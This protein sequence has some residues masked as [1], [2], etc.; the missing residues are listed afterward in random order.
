MRKYKS[1]TDKEIVI[2]NDKP[3]WKSD[4]DELQIEVSKSMFIGITS[5][6]SIDYMTC[7]QDILLYILKV[8]N[9]KEPKLKLEPNKLYSEFEFVGNE[10]WINGYHPDTEFYNYDSEFWSDS[11]DSSLLKEILVFKGSNCG[12]LDFEK[13]IENI[14]NHFDVEFEIIGSIGFDEMYCSDY[15]QKTENLHFTAYNYFIE[16]VNEYKKQHS[17]DCNKKIYKLIEI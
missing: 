7:G 16:K 9:N 4:F 17:L 11:C 15:Y 1:I 3:M 14:N 12:V 13:T 10:N 2:V 6:S 8:K 5:S